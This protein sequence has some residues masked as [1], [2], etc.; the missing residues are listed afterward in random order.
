VL[1]A[2]ANDLPRSVA[3]GGCLPACAAFP[4]PLQEACSSGRPEQALP[5]LVIGTQARPPAAPPAGKIKV[6]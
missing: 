5:V 1:V 3:A 2:A 4:L 6:N